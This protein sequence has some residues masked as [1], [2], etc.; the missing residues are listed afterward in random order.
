V[1]I[2][3]TTDYNNIDCNKARMQAPRSLWDPTFVENSWIGQYNAWVNPILPK[4][5]ASIDAHYPGTKLAVTEYNFGGGAHIS[6]G[7]AQADT[8]GIFG[9]QG[10]YLGALWVFSGGS[11]F[12]AAAFKLYRNYDN[13]GSNYG[14]TALTTSYT[15]VSDLSAFASVDAAD[16][17]KLHV[18]L[19]NKNYDSA[20]NISVQLSGV[21]RTYTRARVFGFDSSSASVTERAGRPERAPFGAR[22]RGH[23]PASAVFQRHPAD[24]HLHAFVCRHG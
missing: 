14:D 9:A 6:G 13:A 1:R 12:Q 11:Q 5:R 2:N 4:L 10:V 15:A 8:L 18:I 19:L 3:D 7:I 20:G 17:K 16:D 23:Q 21:S 22:G 24:Q